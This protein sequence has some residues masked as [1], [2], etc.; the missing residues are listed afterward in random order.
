M[1]C[2]EPTLRTEV[3][4][5]FQRGRYDRTPLHPVFDEASLCHVGF[6]VRGRRVV[7]PTAFGRAG[8]TLYLYGAPLSRML[9]ALEIQRQPARWHRQNGNRQR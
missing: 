5:R 2:Y 3:K 6:V 9:A 8:Q 7:I 4:C 1:K